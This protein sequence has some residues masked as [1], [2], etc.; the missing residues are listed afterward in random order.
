MWF[1]LNSCSTGMKHGFQEDY[2]IIPAACSQVHTNMTFVSFHQ[3]CGLTGTRPE[4]PLFKFGGGSGKIWSRSWICIL[5]I[6]L[7]CKKGG[8]FLFLSGNNKD[9]VDQP[10]SRVR[11]TTVFS[12]RGNFY[13]MPRAN[14]CSI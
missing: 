4:L 5:H 1:C 13:N 8:L 6:I 12:V 3:A 2:Q 7:N 11:R 9:L 14:N 10:E